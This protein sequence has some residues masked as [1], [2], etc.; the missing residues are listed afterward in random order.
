MDTELVATAL[1]PE[2]EPFAEVQAT[3]EDELL[4][5][6]N[7]VG[8][9]IG[10]K[11]TDGR[12][13]G[14]LAVTVL[15]RNKIEEGLLDPADRIPKTLNRRKTDVYEVGEIFAGGTTGETADVGSEEMVAQDVTTLS[16]T[17]RV[18]PAMG[19]YSIGHYKITA[20]TAATGAYD[21]TPFP[22]KPASYYILSNNHVLANSNNANL[23]DPILQPGPYDGGV[24][25]RDFIG[26]L[27]RFITIFFDGRCNYIDAAIAE[28][29]FEW[30]T[31]EIYYIG[32]T[33]SLWKPATLNMIVKK[34]GRTTN[35]TTGRV[36][37]INATVNVNYGGGKVARFC[38]QI[39][40]TDMS[41]PGDSGSLV[42]D[43]YNNPVGL[44]FAGSS[45]VTVL[46]PI[47][48]VQALLR[49][50]LWP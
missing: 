10:H 5:K 42:L 16:L 21:L 30:F 46:N 8:V 43:E 36:T 9:G 48:L 41:A 47:N 44:L 22:S 29:R 38:R 12:D 45:V 4:G 6:T 14:D 40:T 25:P 49:I 15:V 3:S 27:A 20:G 50:R 26:R 32:Y 2:A 35:F 19:G 17:Q 34:T 13:T 23:G 11:W 31:R 33:A 1:E 28:T 37:A 7:V 24:Y 39:L 18:R